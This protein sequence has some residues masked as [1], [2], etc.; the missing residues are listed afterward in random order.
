[1]SL[2]W[3]KL[4]AGGRELLTGN[5]AAA[6]G[7]MLAGNANDGMVMAAYPITPQT[8][9]VKRLADAVSEGHMPRSRFIPVESEH[10]AMA[11]VLGASA[12]GAR[13]FTA[14]SSQGLML[15]AE[16]VF[17]AA[18]ARAPVLLVNV[19]RAL[20]PPWNV[21][22]DQQDALAMRDAGWVQYHCAD[23]QEVLDSVLLG[24][25]LGERLGLPVMVVLE[26]FVLSHTAQEV[27][28]PALEVVRRFLPRYEPTVR[29]DPGAPAVFGGLVGPEL[30]ASFRRKIDRALARVPAVEAELEREHEAL[31]GRHYEPVSAYRCDD[32]EVVLVAAG[33]IASTA[34]VAVEYARRRGLRAGCAR[35]RRFRP[36]PTEALARVL[37]G[38]RRVAVVDRNVSLGGEGVLA[39]E[40]KAALY[41]SGARPAV[42]G[43]IAGLG[44]QD[45]TPEMLA[46]VLTRASD[47]PAC[48][49]LWLGVLPERAPVESA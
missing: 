34:R 14:T 32:A 40:L 9:I 47:T 13:A 48:E 30:Y 27:W 5:E 4:A 15:M 8:D 23:N 20:A 38:A 33:T 17:W 43:F 11:V 22:A 46:D 19:S 41:A 24:Y 39:T 7:A 16:L 18:G 35:V 3:S 21:W 29:L 31:F 25:R 6:L 37:G 26:A 1:M 28:V 49:P 2:A 44:G 10:S 36:F 12:A 42:T 45:V